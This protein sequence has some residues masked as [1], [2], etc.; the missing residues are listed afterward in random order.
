MPY[1]NL[2][3]REG[4][5]VNELDRNIPALSGKGKKAGNTAFP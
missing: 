3:M 2:V 4:I 5:V 1:T